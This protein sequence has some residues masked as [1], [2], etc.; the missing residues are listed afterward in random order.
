MAK[1]ILKYEASVIKGIPLRKPLVVIGRAPGSD[2]LIDN[3]AVSEA[4]QDSGRGRPLL[5]GRHEQPERN[6]PQ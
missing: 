5:R 6:L 1:L 3:L 4:R 2:I